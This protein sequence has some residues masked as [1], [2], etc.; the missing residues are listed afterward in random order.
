VASS[1]QAKLERALTKSVEEH[2]HIYTSEQDDGGTVRNLARELTLWLL[3]VTLVGGGIAFVRWGDVKWRPAADAFI[4][5]GLLAVTV[6][7]YVKLRLR[8]DISHDVFF[9]ALGIHLPDELKDEIL[10]I[11]DCKLVRRNM[12]VYYRLKGSRE[13]GSLH[14]DT[15]TEFEM[16]NLTSHPQSFEHN[17][18][19]SRAPHGGID[20]EHPILFVKAEAQTSYEY[21]ATQIELE[22][23]DHERGWHRSVKLAPRGSARFWATT[24]QILP[25]RFEDVYLLM[26]PTVGLKVR[27][28]CPEGIEPSVT[29]DH[30][31]REEGERLPS[32][33]W[34]FKAAFLPNSTFRIAW[35]AREA[36]KGAV[37]M[38]PRLHVR[39]TSEP[40]VVSFRDVG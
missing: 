1:K 24:R 12:S 20:P 6:D 21:D 11:G 2:I 25:N 8:D 9:A 14:C 19:I 13:D 30:R 22:E 36:A 34:K 33:T 7:R 27:V 35:K 15:E 28:D 10:A 23:R 16:E 38:G 3:A 32:N 18:W 29:F 40:S 39:G 37:P 5:A 26:Q 31:L 4:I 17:V